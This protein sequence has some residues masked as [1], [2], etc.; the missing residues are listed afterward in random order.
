[1][2][3]KKVGLQGTESQAKTRT[4][5]ALWNL[6][7]TKIEV[8]KSELT[9]RVQRSNEKAGDYQSVFEQLE[10]EGAIAIGT[11]NRS[12]KVALTDRG[13]EVLNTGLKSPDFHFGGRQVRAKDV[14]SLLKWIRTL[15]TSVGIPAYQAKPAAAAYA[16]SVGEGITSYKKF[17][18][19]VLEVYDHLNWDYNL[20]NLVP[21]Y[22]IRS[23]IGELVSRA[24]FNEWL[25]EMQ[26]K[27][28]LQ[29]IGGEMREITPDKAEDSI[30]TEL[31]GLCYY[32][33]RLSFE[34]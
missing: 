26:A 30:K 31:G 24:Q 23:E 32:A 29:L 34:D 6:G 7:G 3:S 14:N 15:D 4:L 1:M 10:K 9:K 20:D 17:E 12:V 28:I 25:L 2:P 19:L 16:P 22:R 18:Q 13:L 8:K 5:L 21:I 11:K 27:N 33:K